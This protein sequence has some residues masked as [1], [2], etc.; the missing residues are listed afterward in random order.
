MKY[1]VN[2]KYPSLF[3]NRTVGKE[4][5]GH[6]TQTTHSFKPQRDRFSDLKICVYLICLAVLSYQIWQ[7][8]EKYLEGPT[9][10]ETRNLQQSKT[11]FPDIT[12]CSTAM[13]G[14]HQ[15]K[16]DVRDFETFRNV[17]MALFCSIISI[18]FSGLLRLLL[19]SWEKILRR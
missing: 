14:L 18:A 11:E 15:L 4:V 2:L 13:G 8:F 19:R 3:W 1:D 5:D 9:I 6:Q 16:L 10:Y 12:I 7:C 17:S